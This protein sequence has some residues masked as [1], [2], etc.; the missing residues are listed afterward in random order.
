MGCERYEV[1]EGGGVWDCF[2]AGDGSGMVSRLELE[3]GGRKRNGSEDGK[4]VE[5]EDEPWTGP[6]GLGGRWTTNEPLDRSDSPKWRECRRQ[7]R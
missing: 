4:E 7:S 5:V 6:A 3:D 1:D 2:E